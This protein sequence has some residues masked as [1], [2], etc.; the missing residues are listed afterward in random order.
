MTIRQQLEQILS[1]LHPSDQL[2]ELEKLAMKIRK[3]NGLR[4]EQERTNA[5]FRF[6]Q[7][8]RL[9]DQSKANSQSSPS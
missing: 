2:H 3:Y 4:I 1:S 7:Q 9:H 5:K 8:K 6:K